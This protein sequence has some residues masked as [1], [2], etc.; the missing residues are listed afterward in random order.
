MRTYTAM[1]LQ[2]SARSAVGTLENVYAEKKPATTNIAEVTSIASTWLLMSTAS[3]AEKRGAAPVALSTGYSDEKNMAL[4]A[5]LYRCAKTHA[6]RMNIWK[7]SASLCSWNAS[8]KCCA[9][10]ARLLTLGAALA[11]L[12]AALAALC[13][14]RAPPRRLPARP[15]ARLQRALQSCR[16]RCKYRIAGTPGT[17]CC[18]ERLRHEHDVHG[19]EGPPAAHALGED[20]D[21]VA[22]VVLREVL[23]GGGR[24]AAM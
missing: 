8:S 6:V 13:A 3:T 7:R 10:L 12:G 18:L 20:A 22:V 4:D 16:T 17:R 23:A 15:P 2:I 9:A 5:T 14:A 1:I 21:L 11:A 19:V 24:D